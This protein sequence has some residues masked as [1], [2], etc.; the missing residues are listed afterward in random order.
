M[1]VGR[2]KEG[3]VVT[4]R[5]YVLDLFQETRMLGCKPMDTPMDP[6]GKIDN[7]SHPPDKDKYQRL[8][9][10]VIYLT[11]TRPNIGF[12][13]PTERHMKDVYRILQ[14]LKK[15]PGSEL[16][17]KK[18][19]SKEVEVFTDTDWVGSL[20]DRRSTSGYCSYV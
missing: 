13:D 1:E 20:I 8:V 17:F 14:Y 19:L 15:S 12:T 6:L 10:K 9:G 3:I 4:Q 11:H 5:K 2:T 7:D 18:F 16:Y